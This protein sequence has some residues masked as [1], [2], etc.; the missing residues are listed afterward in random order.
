[1]E[2]RACNVETIVLSPIHVIC[3]MPSYILNQ[4]DQFDQIMNRNFSNIPEICPCER[5]RSIIPD[6]PSRARGVLPAEGARLVRAV[7]VRARA[8]RTSA[9]VHAAAVEADTREY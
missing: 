7:C 4:D 9:N 1:M 6:L 8:L 2:L 3:S 5:D